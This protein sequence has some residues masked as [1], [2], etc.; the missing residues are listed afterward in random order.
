MHKQLRQ[1]AAGLIAILAFAIAYPAQTSGKIEN[2]AEQ[3]AFVT[4]FEV[5]GLKVLLKQRPSAPTAAVGLF[6]RGGVRNYGEKDQG[7]ENLTLNTAIEAGRKFDRPAIRR[8]LAAT[9]SSMAASSSRDYS[10]VSFA[11]TRENFARMWAVLTD[12]MMS[13][14]F[15][16]TDVDRIRTQILAGLRE[17]ETSPDG[18]LYALQDRVIY[19]GHPYSHEV[20]GTPETLA[21]LTPADLR[22][23]HN[24]IMQ[25][26][27]LLLVVVGDIDADELKKQVAN[28]FG[29]LPKGN[30][31]EKPLPKL[32]FSKPTVDVSSR[33]IGTNYI[34]G[35]YAAPSLSDPDYFPMRVA[36]TILQQ[37]VYEEVRVR[38][39]LSYAPNAELNT[40]AANTGHIYVT[41]VDADQAVSVMLDQIRTLQTDLRDEDMIDGMAGQFLTHYYVEQQTN[42]AQAREL[43]QYELLGG[44][45]R[46]SFEFLNRIREVS[47]KDIQTVANKYMKN[48][49]FVVIGDPKAISEEVFL[50]KK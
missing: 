17:T 12:V 26:S 28:S 27:R 47:P 43:A 34:Q 36:T 3:A 5:N 15:A 38:R 40:Q 19:A 6:I 10:A 2:I 13:P 30:Y 44:G 24:G 8:E 21:K 25:T 37:M 1:A 7:I 29:K 4:E 46:N 22:K 42:V 20:N 48:I 49:R 35:V 9:G 45:W 50:Q 14:A 32:D 18:A 33:N 31:K 11:S 39:Q 41:A 16:K 23:Y